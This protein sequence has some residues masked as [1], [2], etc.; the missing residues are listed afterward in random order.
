V[1]PFVQTGWRVSV[2]PVLGCGR[3]REGE[4][5]HGENEE[6]NDSSDKERKTTMNTVS[7]NLGPLLSRIG[8]LMKIL[9]GVFYISEGYPKC[10]TGSS[11]A[12]IMA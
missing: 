1:F 2:D 9:A 4:D 7:H 10:V 3:R 5:E 6:R 12:S 11:V 8:L